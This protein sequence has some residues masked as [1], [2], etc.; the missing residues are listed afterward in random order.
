MTRS[1]RPVVLVTAPDPRTAADAAY[2]ARRTGLYLDAVRRAGGDPRTID[3]TAGPGARRDALAAMDALLLSGGADVHPSRYGRTINGSRDIEPG[4]DALE[5]EAWRVAAERAVPV[6]GICRGLQVVN[7][8]AGGTLT[9]HVDG[10]A[11]AAWDRGPAATHPLRIDRSTRVGRLLSDA[12]F[13]GS[14]VNSF[15]HQAVTPADLAPDLVAVAWAESPVGPVV[16]VLEGRG[17]WW[18]AAVQCHP[19]RTDSTP[20]A[21]ERLFA[22]FVEAAAAADD[23]PGARPTT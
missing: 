15:H 18:I 9:Q 7:V 14:E 8:F 20:P 22:A 16:E 21:F 4:R 10:H 13:D 5:D 23:R 12:G 17:G 6:L 3:E 1:A 19:E 2:I 11:A